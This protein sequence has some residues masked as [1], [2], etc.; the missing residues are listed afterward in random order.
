MSVPS[1]MSASIPNIRE[2]S[3]GLRART[4]PRVDEDLSSGVNSALSTPDSD[5]ERAGTKDDEEAKDKKERKTIG[6]TPA[7]TCELSQKTTC[8]AST[9]QC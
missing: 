7:G 2:D 8:P 1:A 6:F 5:D 3:G 9:A 4:F